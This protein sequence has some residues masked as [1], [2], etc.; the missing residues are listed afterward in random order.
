[1]HSPSI[2]QVCL[3]YT[4][5]GYVWFK[6]G[7][8][9]TNLFAIRSAETEAG[10]FDDLLGVAYRLDGEWHV[11]SWPATTDPSTPL[12]KRPINVAGTAI[13]VPGQYRNA[14]RIGNHRGYE[15]LVQ[16]GAVR[17]WRDRN[18]DDQLDWGSD[19]GISGYYGINIHRARPKGET[20]DVGSYSAGCQVFRSADDFARLMEIARAARD[21][22]GNGF[23]YTLLTSDQIT[24]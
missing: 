16:R 7:D 6:E 22:W 19:A 9:N 5:L 4:D 10:E 15:A 20:P 24:W 21:Q 13:L 3:A 14:Y 18:K 23:T 8:W 11:E 17:V 2:E 1:M 12:L